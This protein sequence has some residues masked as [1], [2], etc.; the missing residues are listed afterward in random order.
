M[1]S[2]KEGNIIGGKESPNAI[3]IN[4]IN[5]GTINPFNF[6]IF[7]ISQLS[8]KKSLPFNTFNTYFYIRPQ[9]KKFVNNTG[10]KGFSNFYFFILL[11]FNRLFWC[12]WRIF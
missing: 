5:P 4:N 6:P 3:H 7:R 8:F 12:I 1:V 9:I 10:Q 2:E 11:P